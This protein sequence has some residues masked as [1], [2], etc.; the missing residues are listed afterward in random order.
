MCLVFW[1]LHS[2]FWHF[3]GHIHQRFFLNWRFQRGETPCFTPPSW[4]TITHSSRGSW[5]NPRLWSAPWRTS[6]PVGPKNRP[7]SSARCGKNG[8]RDGGSMAAMGDQYGRAGI[9]FCMLF[10]AAWGTV[11][12]LHGILGSH[13]GAICLKVHP[14]TAQ[15]Q[16]GWSEDVPS[17]HD[18]QMYV[19]S[20]SQELYKRFFALAPSGQD[21]F[22]QSSTRLCLGKGGFHIWGNDGK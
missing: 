6:S 16:L 21:F 11:R 9:G 13:S 3:G 1:N 20:T 15:N 17:D 22:K 12:K 10:C 2:S 4:I 7:C 14:Q 8:W 18:M 19:R 5:G